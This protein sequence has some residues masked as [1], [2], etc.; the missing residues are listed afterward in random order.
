MI[1]HINYPDNKSNNLQFICNNN[2]RESVHFAGITIF[3]VHLPSR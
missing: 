1:C 3:F 2:D